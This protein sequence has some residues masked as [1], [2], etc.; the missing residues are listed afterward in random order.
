MFP[1]K[2][3]K[4]KIPTSDMVG[5]FAHIR[6]FDIHTGVDLYCDDKTPVY[7]INDGVV[8]NIEDFTGEFSTPPTPWWFNTKSVL[9]EDNE[10]VICYG[11]ITTNLSIGDKIKE[12]DIIGYVSQVLKK[13]KGLPMSMLHIELYEKDV[14]ESIVWNIVEEKPKK[15]KD[16]SNL[17]EKEL[18]NK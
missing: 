8:V 4:Y 17:L 1:I 6:K 16:I 3:Y 15:L 9:V 14:R 12:G 18:F 13:D 7:A 10:N 5:G 11:E 2:N